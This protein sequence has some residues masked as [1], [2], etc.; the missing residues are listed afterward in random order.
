MTPEQTA[1]LDSHDREIAGL[2]DGQRRLW[3]DQNRTA[4]T[5]ASVS[6]EVENQGDDI[7]EIKGDLKDIKNGQTIMTRWLITATFSGLALIL[8]LGLWLVE[9]IS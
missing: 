2:G 9:R 5:L 4:Q 6:T 1:R 8:T 3:Q 7:S